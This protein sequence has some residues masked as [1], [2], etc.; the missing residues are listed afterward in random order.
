MVVG[1]YVGKHFPK[2]LETTCW[3][4]FFYNKFLAHWILSHA[5]ALL[6]KWKEPEVILGN[7]R[8]YFVRKYG[9]LWKQIVHTKAYCP[10]NAV[11]KKC[12]R[13]TFL[14]TSIWHFS[15]RC[16]Q[17]VLRKYRL[18]LHLLKWSTYGQPY[19][20][21]RKASGA[22]SGLEQPSFC[23]LLEANIERNFW[24]DSL[25]RIFGYIAN[26][27]NHYIFLIFKSHENCRNSKVD[28][29]PTKTLATKASMK[30]R[31]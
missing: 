30:L 8:R 7:V 24:Q 5:I 18:L 3:P 23:N 10:T 9:I 31:I 28:C 29:F 16:K 6:A 4:S 27:K 22:F 26:K 15:F 17:V 2:A 19:W 20:Q 1:L 14:F 25:L 12:I 21:S 13:Y 11:H